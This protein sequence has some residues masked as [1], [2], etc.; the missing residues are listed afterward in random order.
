MG[1]FRF[2]LWNQKESDYVEDVGVDGSIS[3]KWI[4]KK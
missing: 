3:L 1:R 4:L 2:C